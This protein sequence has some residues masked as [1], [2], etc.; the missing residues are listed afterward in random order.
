MS[1]PVI[2]LLITKANSGQTRF[3]KS[4]Y[5]LIKGLRNHK[6][7]EEEYIQDSLRECK[8]EIRS[9]DMGRCILYSPPLALMLIPGRQKGHGA[10]EID[11]LG[12]VWL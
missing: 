7:T 11:I 12:D 8:S 6:G 9:Q 1:V 5:D 10:L 3:E 2:R 4:L